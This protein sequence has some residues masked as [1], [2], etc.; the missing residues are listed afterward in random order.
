MYSYLIS[1][2]LKAQPSF[3]SL[4]DDSNN[5]SW[6]IFIKE[7]IYRAKLTR[8]KCNS[9]VLASKNTH[10]I[11]S[12]CSHRHFKNLLVFIPTTCFSFLTCVSVTLRS[13]AIS[14]RSDED[15]YF[16]TSNCFS[17][18]KIWRPVKVVRAFFLFRSPSEPWPP[19]L[20]APLCVSDTVLGE[21]AFCC[22]FG[23]AGSFLR[24]AGGLVPAVPSAGKTIRLNNWTSL[25]RV[26]L[27]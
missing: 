21:V 6:R 3:C 18:S 24:F 5:N 13:F 4:S 9:L 7:I 20:R 10:S 25:N 16:F 11:M 26:L 2:K 19:S 8:T 23:V 12:Q 15:R 17:N 14:A 22:C 27:K 1:Y